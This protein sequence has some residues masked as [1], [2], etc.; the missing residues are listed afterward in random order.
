M[1][2]SVVDPL[3]A[4]E[5]YEQNRHLLPGLVDQLQATLRCSAVGQVRQR[6]DLGRW[7]SRD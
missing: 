5:I 1:A 4:V 7:R 3:E 6:V 2:S